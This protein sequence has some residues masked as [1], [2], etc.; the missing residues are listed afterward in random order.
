MPQPS[1]GGPTE[2][3]TRYTTPDMPHNVSSTRPYSQRQRLMKSM[4]HLQ[5][6]W[7]KRR[8]WVSPLKMSISECYR[9]ALTAY[10]DTA[11]KNASFESNLGPV[12][13]SV[14]KLLRL[15]WD[16]STR[17]MACWANCIKSHIAIYK[18]G[19]KNI[20]FWAVHSA[21]NFSF[22]HVSS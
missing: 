22:W 15:C 20:G 4:A 14:R 6:K 2:Y 1:T 21:Y 11:W 7:K 13:L 10:S 12:A 9:N 17:K 5:L 3:Y 16:M 8:I 19:Y 18:I